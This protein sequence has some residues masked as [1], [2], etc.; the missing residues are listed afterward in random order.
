MEPVVFLW[1]ALI[2]ALALSF[3]CR[4]SWPDAFWMLRVAAACLVIPVAIMT[5]PEY[6][7]IVA[8]TVAA[9]WLLKTAI[10]AFR[11]IHWSPPPKRRGRIPT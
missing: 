8:S 5:P 11:D 4:T 10:A 7:A 1:A 2:I 9:G 6:V 3:K